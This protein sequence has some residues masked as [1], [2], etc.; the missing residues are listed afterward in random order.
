[1][2][3]LQRNLGHFRVEKIL[4]VQ[5]S[6]SLWGIP[7]LA[8]NRRR[9]H[10]RKSPKPDLPEKFLAGLIETRIENSAINGGLG[11]NANRHE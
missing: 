3:R 9:C 7:Q 4:V 10:Q 1:L 2:D 8:G 5:K 11:V 6:Y